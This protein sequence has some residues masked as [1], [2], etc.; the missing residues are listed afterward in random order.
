M[1]QAD[2]PDALKQ[3][4]FFSRAVGFFA[5]VAFVDNCTRPLKAPGILPG[6]SSA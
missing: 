6:A 4:A 2:L 3:I 1:G 5:C